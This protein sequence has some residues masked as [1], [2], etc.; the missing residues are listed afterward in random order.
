MRFFIGE[1]YREPRAFGICRDNGEWIVYKNKDD[2][3]RFIRYRG[4]DEEVAVEEIFGKL[5]DE[6]HLRGI[7][8]ENMK[9]PMKENL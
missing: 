6:C 5:L 9:G 2:G 3:N 8:P 4:L 7:V 1:N